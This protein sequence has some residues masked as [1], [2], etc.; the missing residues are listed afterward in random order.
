MILDTLFIVLCFFVQIYNEML[1]R[2]RK[3]IPFNLSEAEYLSDI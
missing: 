1:R 2:A 3:R